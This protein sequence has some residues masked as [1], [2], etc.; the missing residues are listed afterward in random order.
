M[1]VH[2]LE[3]V[4]VGSAKAYD[5]RMGVQNTFAGPGA[6]KMLVGLTFTRQFRTISDFDGSRVLF[7]AR[8][9]YSS[10]SFA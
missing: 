1:D 2:K 6:R 9:T 5:V 7:R 8:S 10:I 3:W 4:R